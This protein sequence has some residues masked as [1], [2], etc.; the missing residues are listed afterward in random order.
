MVQRARRLGLLFAIG[1]V[2]VATL[3]QGGVARSFKCESQKARYDAIHAKDKKLQERVDHDGS[4]GVTPKVF[5]G[6]LRRL[7]QAKLQQKA[8]AQALQNCRR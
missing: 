3:A 6:D 8:A 1:G 2:L 5:A 7:Q 4:G